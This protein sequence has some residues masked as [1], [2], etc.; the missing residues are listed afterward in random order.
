MKKSIT[1]LL[2]LIATGVF[3]Q[4]KVG[5]NTNSPVGMLDVVSANHGLLVPRLSDT[6]IAAIA[7]PKEGELVWAS[8]QRC[9]KFFATIWKDMGTCTTGGPLGTSPTQEDKIGIGTSSP[10]VALDIA[11]ASQGIL[12]PRIAVPATAI[13]VPIE[14]ELVWNSTRKCFQ[15]YANT[16]WKNLT[17]CN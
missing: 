17:T 5:I 6:E 13:T 7:S 4:G 8:Q 1:L 15:Y 14:S 12:I 2:M 3:A 9:F 16:E 11:S 10:E